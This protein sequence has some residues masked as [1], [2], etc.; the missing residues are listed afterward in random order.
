MT[1]RLY[2]ARFAGLALF[3][4]AVLIVLDFGYGVPWLIRAPLALL[5]GSG[6]MEIFDWAWKAWRRRTR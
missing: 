5:A 3:V 6:F 4:A 2:W 1:G